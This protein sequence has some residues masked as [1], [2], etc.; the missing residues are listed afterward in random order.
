MKLS[1]KEFRVVRRDMREV[2]SKN[3][4]NNKQKDDD[5]RNMRQN[6]HGELETRLQQ[7]QMRLF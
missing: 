3:D 5:R 6:N 4:L 7:K 1:R 2:L